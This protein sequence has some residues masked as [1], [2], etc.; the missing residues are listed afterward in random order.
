[1]ENIPIG[2]QLALSKTTASIDVRYGPYLSKQAVIDT[3]GENGM[4]V[5]AEGIT[6]GIIESGEIVEYWFK[7]G[8]DIDHLVKKQSNAELFTVDLKDIHVE[9]LIPTHAAKCTFTY[10]GEATYKIPCVYDDANCVLVSCYIKTELE[11][12]NKVYLIAGRNVLNVW[13]DDEIPEWVLPYLPKEVALML[14]DVYNALY[15]NMSEH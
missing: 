1:M 12:I 2:L 14:Q 13:A 7:G 10:D 11:I 8:I 6:V 5:L 4:D 15:V 3:L 9:D